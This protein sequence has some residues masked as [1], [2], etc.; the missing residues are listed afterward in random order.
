MG[1]IVKRGYF[2]EGLFI[3]IIWLYIGINANTSFANQYNVDFKVCEEFDVASPEIKA[4]SECIERLIAANGLSV[5]SNEASQMI[6]A[7][8]TGCATVQSFLRRVAKKKNGQKPVPSCY[9][10]SLAL[11]ELQAAE[12]T[13]SGCAEYFYGQGNLSS[14]LDM[15]ATSQNLMNSRQRQALQSCNIWQTLLTGMSK[16]FSPKDKVDSYEPPSCE[17]IAKASSHFN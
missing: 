3:S 8:P 2:L 14:C 13:W 1:R 7:L 5:E 15:L 10:I 11:K 9:H 6:Y 17:E 4:L 16:N 12:I